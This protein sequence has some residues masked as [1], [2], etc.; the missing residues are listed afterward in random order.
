MTDDLAAHRAHL[1]RDLTRIRAQLE[2]ARDQKHESAITYASTPDGAAETYRHYE[3]SAAKDKPRL[4]EI[5]LSGLAMSAEEYAKRR[6]LGNASTNDGPLQAIPAGDFTNP[7][8]AVLI[9]HRIMGTYRN[10][11]ASEAPNSVQISLMRLEP[12][13]TTRRRMRLTVPTEMGLFTNT[14]AE[15]VINARRDPK[16]WPRLRTF[17]GA[18]AATALEQ[19]L[20]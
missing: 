17:L 14:L 10:P 19:A 1:Q 18:D 9:S 3:L 20:Q 13:D 4:R 15:V 6:E 11:P 5:Y 16:T 7:I 12:D 2:K 8:T